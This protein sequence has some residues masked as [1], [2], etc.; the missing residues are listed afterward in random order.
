MTFFFWYLPK[1]KNKKTVFIFAG[2]P[3][4]IIIIIH[5]CVG[6]WNKILIVVLVADLNCN[7]YMVSDVLKVRVGRGR[8]KK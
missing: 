3:I 4:I 6:V 1:T 7:Y 5:L 2:A 8:K